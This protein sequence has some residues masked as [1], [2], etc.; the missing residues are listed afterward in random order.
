MKLFKSVIF[1]RV[2]W[3]IGM[4]ILGAVSS[5]VWESMLK[6]MVA[7]VRDTI[8]Y[9]VTFG[10]NRYRNDIYCEIA[11]GFCEKPS[12]LLFCT[13]ISTF[14][15]F[16]LAIT[17][18]G[19]IISPIKKVVSSERNR[20]IFLWLATSYIIVAS[21][22]AAF[23]AARV[24]YINSAVTYFQQCR[25]IIAPYIKQEEEKMLVSKFS[26]IW[27]RDDYITVVSNIEKIASKNGQRVPDFKIW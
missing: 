7:K 12:V 6:P 18:T 22:F 9:M 1:R 4:I 5:G 25:T 10:V 20:K 17:T 14:L 19:F 21:V 23:Y 13:M 24:S 27:S 2:L 15:G 26:Q 16:V 11:Q 3:V 8:L